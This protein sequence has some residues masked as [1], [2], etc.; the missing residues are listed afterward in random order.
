MLRRGRQTAPATSAAM[1]ITPVV[2]VEVDLLHPPAVPVEFHDE[3]VG[4]VLKAAAASTSGWVQLD[5]EARP[6][7]R[8]FYRKLVHDIKMALPPEIKLSVT[9]LAWW[10]RSNAWLDG[11]EADEI[12]PMFFRMG[13]DSQRMNQLLANS[14]RSFHSRCSAKTAGFAV[15]E[16]PPPDIQQRYFKVYWFDYR[17]WKGENRWPPK[18]K[19]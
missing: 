19:P 8:V 6:S 1:L 4:S 17:G 2:H 10:C 3:I 16:P 11:L 12:V 7:H 14:P 13:K 5:Y 9:A 15:Q 18:T